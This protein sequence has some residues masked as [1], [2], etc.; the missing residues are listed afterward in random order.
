[1][2][3]I[4]L[5]TPH[6]RPRPKFLHALLRGLAFYLAL[7]LL[8]AA[9]LWH[10][11]DALLLAPTQASAGQ[12]AL[13]LDNGY[14]G[15]VR[16]PAGAV[17]GTVVFY[18]GNGGTV[19]DVRYVADAVT[20]L[21]Y[22]AV[23]LEYP[24]YGARDGAARSADYRARGIADFDLVARRFPGERLIVVGQSFG[25]GVAAAV[26]GA[27]AHQVCGVLLFTPW[28][29]LSELVQEKLPMF[30]A[31]LLLQSDYPSDVALQAYAGPVTIVAAERDTL[32]PVHHA[33][34]LAQHHPGS[35]FELLKGVGHNDWAT[36][37]TTV[38]WRRWLARSG[39]GDVCCSCSG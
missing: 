14:V 35:Q 22:R 27:R 31:R 37:A 20:A 10:Y 19:A 16:A 3:G 15:I 11:Q 18:H 17:Q 39:A 8:A 28:N 1:M 30:P 2:V 13:V 7:Y 12:D 25:A 26:T 24:G 34:T 36:R 38:D 32:I 33:R 9:A 23:L 4:P 29:R 21:G 6:P 5:M